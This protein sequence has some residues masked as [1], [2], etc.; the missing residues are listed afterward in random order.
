MG[1]TRSAS[2]MRT[3]REVYDRIRWDPRLDP[4]QAALLRADFFAPL[5]LHRFDAGRDAWVEAP[6]EGPPAIEPGPAR[7]LRAVTWNVLSD[8]HERERVKTPLRVPAIVSALESTAADVIALQEVSPAVHEALLAA[9]WV[10]ARYTVSE[11]PRSPAL[12]GEGVLFL[13][14]VPVQEL[15]AH[16]YSRAKRAVAAALRAGDASLVVAQVHLP[17]DFAADAART[18]RAH[19]T[20]LLDALGPPGGASP[21]AIVLGDFNWDDED[22]DDLLGEHGFTDAWTSARGQ[23]IDTFDPARNALANMLTH[24]GEPSRLDRVLTRDGSRALRSTAADLFA[25]EAI[26]AVD[27]PLFASDH[28]G[29]CVDLALRAPVC[30]PARSV[31]GRPRRPPRSR[32]PRRRRAPEH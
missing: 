22:L 4:A 10:R 18:R 26:V 32:P 31:A 15:G 2:P 13:F 17:S 9:P 28:F 8:Q 5:P 16:A 25:T 23:P 1:K 21:P 11:G 12:R 24:G 29:V 14:R 30:A 20:A 6:P 3:S 19:L 27:E 7:R